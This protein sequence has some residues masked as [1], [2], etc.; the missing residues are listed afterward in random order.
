MNYLDTI[1]D[2]AWFDFRF[3][4][5]ENWEVTGHTLD[6]KEGRLELS[7][8]ESYTCRIHWR[9]ALNKPDFRVAHQKWFDSFVKK[10][11]LGFFPSNPVAQSFKKGPFLI[12]K[13]A[14]GEPFW[15]SLFSKKTGVVLDLYFPVFEEAWVESETFNQFLNS[16]SEN[17]TGEQGNYWS[18]WGLKANM[19]EGYELEEVSCYPASVGMTFVNKHYHKIRLHRWGLVSELLKDYN[20]QQFYRSALK[21]ER[22][23][24]DSV[25]SYEN[26]SGEGSFIEFRERGMKNMDKLLGS[27]W[28]GNG[29]CLHQKDEK[30]IYAFELVAPKKIMKGLEFET[31]AKRVLEPSLAF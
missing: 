21:Q 7:D 10:N 19:P 16:Y 31:L 14:D 8:R 26:P 13:I 11:K 3:T 22:A 12:S 29:I 4:L 24:I 23:V 5:P 28:L 9:E 15:V 30:R 1:R 27:W 25:Q 2:L 17:P 18:C 20:L 6:H